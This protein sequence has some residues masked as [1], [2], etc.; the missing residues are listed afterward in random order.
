MRSFWQVFFRLAKVSRA[1]R[2][3]S[4]RVEPEILRLMT[5]SRMSLSLELLCN[6]DL[7]TLEDEEQLSLVVA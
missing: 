7:G 2:P 5:Y 3:F 4:E 6:G 1:R